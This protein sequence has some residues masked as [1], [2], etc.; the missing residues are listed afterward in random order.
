MLYILNN[1]H[2]HLKTLSATEDYRCKQLY[3]G[4]IMATWLFSEIE[5]Y[6]MK[7]Y[8]YSMDDVFEYG[9]N[10]HSSLYMN[11]Q[12]MTYAVLMYHYGYYHELINKHYYQYVSNILSM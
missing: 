4:G 11:I 3:G 7:P 5:K 6:A 9:V 1:Y 8:H 12:E 10:V 2:K